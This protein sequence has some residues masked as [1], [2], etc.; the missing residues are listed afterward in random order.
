MPYPAASAALLDALKD[1]ASLRFDTLSLLEDA[2][3]TRRRIDAL[4]SDN[5]E[6]L[7]MVHQ[8]EESYDAD[9]PTAAGTLGAG[10]LPS[11]EELAA[12]LERFLRDQ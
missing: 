5:D 10:P 2:A 4:V 3:S 1:V 6:H 11:G 12:E 7:A 9:E 8:L